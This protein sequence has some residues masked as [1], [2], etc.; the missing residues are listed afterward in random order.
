LKTILSRNYLGQQ[1]ETEINQPRVILKTLTS[2]L[3]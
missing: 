1:R 2:I 3:D